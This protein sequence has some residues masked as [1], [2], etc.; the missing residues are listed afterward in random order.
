[1]RA[2]AVYLCGGGAWLVHGWKK[3]LVSWKVKGDCRVMG[4]QLV[5]G[6]EQGKGRRRGRKQCVEENARRIRGF[7][8]GGKEGTVLLSP[9][10]I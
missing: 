4:W 2:R 5:V 7:V 6:E 9:L 3:P 1:M 10:S 8:S